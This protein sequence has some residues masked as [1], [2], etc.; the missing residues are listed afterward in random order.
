MMDRG[1]LESYEMEKFNEKVPQHPLVETGAQK[2]ARLAHTWLFSAKWALQHRELDSVLGILDKAQAVLRAQNNTRKLAKALYLY[3]WYYRARFDY[4]KSI[5]YAT[6]SAQLYAAV[7]KPAKQGEN[8]HNTGYCL[9]YLAKYQDAIPFFLQ[10]IPIF[11]TLKDHVKVADGYYNIGKSYENLGD[12]PRAIENLKQ[13]LDFNTKARKSDDRGRDALLIATLTQKQGDILAALEYLLLAHSL[14]QKKGR[15][16]RLREITSN[17]RAI[18]ENLGSQNI[19]P[20]F[21]EV[22]AQARQ[23]FKAPLKSHSN[24]KRS[25]KKEKWEK[26]KKEKT[27]K[28]N[29][30]EL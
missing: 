20:E 27:K 5:E 16:D 21:R 12:L 15:N 30:R 17:M 19:P 10:S 22:V 24:T 4:Q 18:L 13:S 8:L 2:D 9:Y 3:A 1:E 7:G 6:E 25:R 23:H 29:E 14:N 11:L 28:S 26:K